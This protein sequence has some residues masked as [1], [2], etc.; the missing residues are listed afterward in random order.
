MNKE[1]TLREEVQPIIAK[2]DNI[3]DQCLPITQAQ[4]KSIS[5]ALILA[6]GIR[7]LRDLFRSNE[8]IK[9]TIESMQDTELGFMTDRSPAII[10]AAKKKGKKLDCYTYNEVA[11]CC[12][13]ALLRGYRLTDNEFNIIAGKF[14]PAKNGKYRKIIDTE[15]LTDF[16][17]STTPPLFK[18]E[19]RLEYGKP[20]QVQYAEV[21]AFAT[22]RMNGKKMSIGNQGS[23]K[24][25]DDLILKIRVNE[26]MGDDGVKG[27]AISKLFSHVLMRIQGKI[28]DEATD[29]DYNNS[30]T[31]DVT[32]E[33]NDDLM[34]K[35]KEQANEQTQTDLA[36]ESLKHKGIDELEICAYYGVDHIKELDINH[37]Q[38]IIKI[39]ENIEAEIL[40]ID[41]FK[42][43]SA[44]RFEMKMKEKR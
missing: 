24:G 28:Y 36:I 37:L 30:K 20:T 2:I 31:I 16:E 26:Y 42:I 34:Q 9:A 3:V 41:E 12:I 29:I 14:Y 17:F 32:K 6:K 44:E 25:K 33:S 11:E 35:I 5:D 23:T 8:A 7:E 19:T 1:L 39:A 4:G 38:D 27:K 43:K 13:N 15:G 40:T 18:T 10:E 21:E 22:W